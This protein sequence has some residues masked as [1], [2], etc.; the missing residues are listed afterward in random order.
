MPFVSHL[1]LPA[2]LVG[3]GRRLEDP[4]GGV[5]ASEVE[6]AGFPRGRAEPFGQVKCYDT[7]WQ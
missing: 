7:W 5:S 4:L 1:G 3:I 2:G 6:G